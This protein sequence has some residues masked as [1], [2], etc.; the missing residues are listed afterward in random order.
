M[1]TKNKENKYHTNE[2]HPVTRKKIVSMVLCL[3]GNIDDTLYY[4]EFGLFKNTSN[5]P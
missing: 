5:V 2:M 1:L 4:R 3:A